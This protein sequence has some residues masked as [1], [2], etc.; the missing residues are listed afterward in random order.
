MN[1]SGFTPDSH[2]SPLVLRCFSLFKKKNFRNFYRHFNFIP[3]CPSS[4]FFPLGKEVQGRESS[5]Y[6]HLLLFLRNNFSC[7]LSMGEVFCHSP[8]KVSILVLKCSPFTFTR[9]HFRKLKIYLESRS[10]M[11]G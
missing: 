6:S 10:Y 8:S 1:S 2:L 4:M 7:P 3:F 5:A 9:V 11:V